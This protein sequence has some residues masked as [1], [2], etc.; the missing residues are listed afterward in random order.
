[1]QNT[2]GLEPEQ[3]KNRMRGIVDDV[4]DFDI[5]VIRDAFINWRRSSREIPTPFDIRSRCEALRTKGFEGKRLSDFDGDFVAYKK[6]L[7]KN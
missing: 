3:L 1:M 6:Y 5:Q 4:V 7:E 2:Y